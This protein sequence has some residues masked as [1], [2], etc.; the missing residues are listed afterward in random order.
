MKKNEE[1]GAVRLSL[2]KG[3]IPSNLCYLI[4]NS[5]KKCVDFVSQIEAY[6]PYLKVLLVSYAWISKTLELSSARHANRPPSKDVDVVDLT[7][8]D[9]DLPEVN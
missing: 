7:D 2:R 9:D 5:H 6:N 3:I 8:N 4:F 1:L